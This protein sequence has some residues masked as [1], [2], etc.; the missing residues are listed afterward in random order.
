MKLPYYRRRE[1][2]RWGRYPVRVIID[3]I[4]M[5]PRARQYGLKYYF[6]TA[7][8]RKITNRLKYKSRL[9]RAGRS[10]VQNGHNK[11]LQMMHRLGPICRGC[12]GIFPS[13]FLTRD[14][15]IPLISGGD[16]SDAN[17][18]LL[19]TECHDKKTRIENMALTHMKNSRG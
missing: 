4:T 10:F 9:K 7:Y 15:I 6:D 1:N 19:C 16:S 13:E 5:W 17:L 8:R 12:L 18:Q 3:I 14:H 2:E 11:K